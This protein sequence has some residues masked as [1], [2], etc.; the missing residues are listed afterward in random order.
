MHVY[1]NYYNHIKKFL[2]HTIL[3]KEILFAKYKNGK[4]RV[5]FIIK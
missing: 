2:H 4:L 3:K 5:K 1:S